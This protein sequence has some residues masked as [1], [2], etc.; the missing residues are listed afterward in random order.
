MGWF[1]RLF[2]KQVVAEV[3]KA[4]KKPKI[5]ISAEES[6]LDITNA[7]ESK[8]ITFRGCLKGYDYDQ[9]LMN[10]QKYENMVKLFQLSDYYTDADEIIRGIIKE[11]YVPFACAEKWKL[12]GADETIK[13]RYEDYY[14]R[15]DLQHFMESFFLQYFKYA[16]VYVY[17]MPNGKL[18]TL[19]V[20]L[21]RIE[22]VAIN[23]EPV[24][25]FKCGVI[26]DSFIEMYGATALQKFI[27]DGSLDV[28]LSAY[29]PEVT[30]GVKSGA[31]YVQLNPLNTFVVQDSKEEWVQYATPFIAA[32]LKTLAKKTLIS[33]YEDAR[34]RLGARG[35]V[36]ATYGDTKEDVLPTTEDL[37]AVGQM[38]MNAITTSGLAVGNK[39][40][41][42][43]FIQSDMRDLFEFDAYKN[44]NLALLSAGGLSSIVVTGQAGTGLSFGA[45]QLNVQTAAMRIRQAKDGF[46]RMM[47]KINPTLNGK[48]QGM[49][50]AASD[51]VPCFTFPP[52]DLQGNRAFQE[53][54]LKLWDKGVLSYETMLQAHGM[55]MKQEAERRKKE[56]TD[57]ID[58][59]F[60]APN[61]RKDEEEQVIGRP[62][63]SDTERNSD[64]ANSITGRNP[65]PSNPDGSEAQMSTASIAAMVAAT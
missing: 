55:D 42:T 57:G 48:V 44:V 27:E 63:L 2:R 24:L 46:A 65:K 64:T 25:D 15:I 23:N 59:L 17:R 49:P 58:E 26:R 30:D 13:Q 10:K 16:N 11:A 50:Y 35:F 38:V 22:S 52:T 61:Q 14:R 12:V 60:I 31:M 51:R 1:D 4:E 56:K 5:A 21:I 39:W 41:D 45:S 3:V 28:R 9:L 6:K 40:L 29:P 54:C 62:T 47:N 53:M 36:L 37:N 32:C 19:P 18:I 20:H 43:K 34:L 33:E 7:Y 8:N